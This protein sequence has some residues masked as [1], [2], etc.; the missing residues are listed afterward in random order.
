MSDDAQDRTTPPRDQQRV[1]ITNHIRVL[2]G[3]KVRTAGKRWIG[4]AVWDDYEEECPVY[5]TREQA[6]AHAECVAQE[7]ANGER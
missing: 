5:R 6:I 2:W 3:A 4:W 7:Y 1:E